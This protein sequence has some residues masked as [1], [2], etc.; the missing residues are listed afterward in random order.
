MGEQHT[1]TPAPIRLNFRSEERIVVEPDDK[2]RFVVTMKEAALAC[3]RVENVK[4][5]QDDF[6]RFLVYLEKW[7]E[8]HANLVNSVFVNVGD[9]ALTILVCTLNESYDTGLDDTITDLDLE[10]VQKFPW[11]VAEVMQVPGSVQRGGRIPF[12]KVILVYGD[13]KRAQTKG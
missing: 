9:G 5:W 7:A 1:K 12:E 8:T 11:L 4:E 13:G 6:D 3:K 2:D 10:L